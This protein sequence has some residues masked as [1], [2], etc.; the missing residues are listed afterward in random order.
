MPDIMHLV[1]IDAPPERVYQALTS[2]EGIRN[3]WTRDADLDN[4]IG[5]IGE[6]RFTYNGDTL[7]TKAEVTELVPF[8][9]VSWK[10]V[11][12]FRPEWAGT[13]IEYRLRAD[14]NGTVVLF[15]HRGFPQ[16]DENYAVCT[17][18]WGYYLMSLQHYLQTGRGA[19]SPEVDFARV[20]SKHAQR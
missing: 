19:P 17:T 14:A 2:A 20:I 3:W 6:F 16:A 1:R 11:S 18:G 8:E 4:R 12:S 13:A 15:A 10:T 9:R 5:G 7:A